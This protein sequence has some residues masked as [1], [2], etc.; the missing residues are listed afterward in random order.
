MEGGTGDVPLVSR[1]DGQSSYWY[2]FGQRW[3]HLY[4]TIAPKT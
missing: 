2:V 4:Y 3:L 1:E